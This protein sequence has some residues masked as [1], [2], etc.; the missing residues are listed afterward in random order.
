M[1]SDNP[2]AGLPP[3]PFNRIL[4]CTRY[5]LSCH[6]LSRTFYLSPDFRSIHR[7]SRP[8]DMWRVPTAKVSF[9]FLVLSTGD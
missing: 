7:N 9:L 2:Y 5:L 3:I 1:T 6:V 8:R 4:V